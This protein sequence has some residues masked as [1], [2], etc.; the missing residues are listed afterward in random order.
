MSLSKEQIAEIREKSPDWDK[1]EMFT[2]LNVLLDDLE[3]ANRVVEA[4]EEIYLRNQGTNSIGEFEA[5][6]DLGQAIK[7]YRGEA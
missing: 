3:A 5:M 2:M 6:F 7:A 4:A 1:A